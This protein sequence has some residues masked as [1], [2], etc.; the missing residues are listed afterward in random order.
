MKKE[1]KKTEIEEQKSDLTLEERVLAFGSGGLAS[2]GTLWLMGDNNYG[3][4][5]EAVFNIGVPTLAY[6]GATASLY[7]LY[8]PKYSNDN[9]AR[10]TGLEKK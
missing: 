1:T 9:P 3:T 8:S 2:L 7:L 5:K 4:L 10:D 6:I